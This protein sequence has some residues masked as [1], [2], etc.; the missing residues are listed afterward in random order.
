MEWTCLYLY[1]DIV[2]DIPAG[3][4]DFQVP[5]LHVF[6]GETSD[7]RTNQFIKRYLFSICLLCVHFAHLHSAC[8]TAWSVWV[9][10]ERGKGKSNN[11]FALQRLIMARVINIC[12]CLS[13]AHAVWTELACAVWVLVREESR[14]QHS[15]ATLV[16]LIDG[17]PIHNLFTHIYLL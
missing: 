15:A 3:W 17:N 11:C 10:C 5:H 12:L 7:Q 9:D 1:T 2:A 8:C 16:H 14:Q 4:L 6:P 13:A